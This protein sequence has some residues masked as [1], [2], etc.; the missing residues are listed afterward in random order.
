MRALVA[1]RLFSGNRNDL[2]P[3]LNFGLRIALEIEPPRGMLRRTASGGND[4]ELVLVTEEKKGRI[5]LYAALAASGG[6]NEQMLSP[7]YF[8]TRQTIKGDMT[9]HKKAL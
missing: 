2:W 5:A 4:N 8:P 6:E 7:S 3:H 1:L 9:L